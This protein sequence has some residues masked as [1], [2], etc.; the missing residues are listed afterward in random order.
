LWTVEINDLLFANIDALK[1][2]FV[3]SVS[4]TITRSKKPSLK[5]TLKLFSETLNVSQ[6]MVKY[7]FGMSKMTVINEDF[8][9]KEYATI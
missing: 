9:E 8:G 3:N 7:C 5:D 1:N 2:I 6:Q 4:P